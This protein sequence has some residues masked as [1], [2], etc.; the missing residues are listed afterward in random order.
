[1]SLRNLFQTS[2]PD[3]AVEIDHAHVAAARL[4]WRGSQAIISAH[5]SEALPPG[6]VAP[7]LTAL[8]VSDV[9]A[10]SQSIGRALGQLGGGR[11]SRV[12]LVI[13]DTVAKVSLLK[14][15]KV[16]AKSADQREIV[17]WQM[18]KTAPF[19][20]DLWWDE[21]PVAGQLRRLASFSR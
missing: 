4:S 19:P 10:L 17:R 8:N 16:P 7:G 21:P 13:P 11:P 12:S 14:L 5:A 9:P 2:A 3:V 15:E 1:M 6:L 20:I 18:K